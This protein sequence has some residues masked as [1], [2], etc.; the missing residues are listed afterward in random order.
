MP[1]EEVSDE[2][3]EDVVGDDEEGGED[4]PDEAFVQV[5]DHEP[6]LDGDEEGG[7]D[8]PAEEAELVLEVAV[9]ETEDKS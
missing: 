4:V 3:G 2:V 6:A 8:D 9:F 5:V 7:D 1:A